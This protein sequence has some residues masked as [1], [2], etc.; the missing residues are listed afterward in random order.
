MRKAW[1]I[2]LGVLHT[3]W[4]RSIYD[5]GKAQWTVTNEAKNI[6]VP[7]KWPSQVHLDL[8]AA[9]VIDDPYHGLNDFN[10]RWIAAQNWTYASN[11]IKGLKSGSGIATWLVF[12]GLDTYTTIKLCDEIIAAT[13]NQFRQYYYDVTQ[14]VNKCNSPVLSINFGSAP[15]IID[16]I[17]ASPGQEQW[18]ASVV[19]PFEYPNR[20]FVRKEQ[21]DFGWDWGP[22]FAPAGPW[23]AGR[24]VQLSQNKELYEL[25]TD[26]D[27]YR[28]GQFN[29]FSPDQSQPWVVNASI[30]F[31]GNLPSGH[32]IDISIKE[33][34]N[35]KST[36]YS[37]RLNNLTSSHLTT[38]GTVT[39]GAN[40]PKLWWPNGL[41]SPNL[42]TVTISVF[43]SK[44]NELLSVQKR[45]GFRTIVLNTGNVTDA[46][47]AQ[48]TTP[49]SN[50]HFEIN[51]H[52]FYAK[53]SNL[54]PPDAFWPRVT[55]DR[56]NHLFESALE[57]NHNMIRVWSSGIYL[58]D[59]MY[60]MA[61]ERG[62]L[63][64]SEFE[65]SDTLYPDDPAFKENVIAEVTYNVRRLNRHPSIAS[66]I[67]GNEFENLLLPI[68]KGAD[69]D[70]YG[71][72]LGQYEDL[73]I[74][75]IFP[76]VCENSHSISYSPSSA[77]HGWTEIDL[78][79]P[80]PMVERYDNTTPGYIYG[81][82]DFYN[83]DPSVSFDYSAYPVGRF[84][85]EF[86]YHSM[87]SLASWQQAIDP[88]D[89]EFNSTVIVFRNHHSPMGGLSTTNTA[90]SLPGMGQM[91]MAVQ[92][93]YP[94]PNKADSV[95]NFSAWCHAT[96]IFQADMYKSEVQFYRRGSGMPE[97]QLGSL[98]WQLNDIWQAPTWAGIE[99]DGRWKVMPYFMKD[100]FQNVIVS[101]FY[102]YGNG[103]LEIWV[104]SDLWESVS[105]TVNMTW[106]NL[107][108][109]PIANNAG[110]PSSAHFTVGAINTTLV[111]RT[112]VNTDLTLPD[113]EDA[114]LLLSVSA[115]G[116][117]PN[118][119]KS[120]TFT[121]KNH[122]T[123]AF[124]N[125][126]KLRNPELHLSYNS[127]T[128]KF[129]V[130]SASKGGVS[131]YTWLTLPSGA[132]GH[133]DD[134][135]FILLPGEK[136]EVGFTLASD[137]TGGNWVNDVTVESIWDQ[138]TP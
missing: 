5:L 24:F 107:A 94:I 109:E 25:N 93:Y 52:E 137:S 21:S 51:G 47:I 14:I 9:G 11:P 12:D 61:D 91:T 86:G 31:I 126:A 110:M 102:N 114:L 22:A 105:G 111:H 74:S 113:P 29:N 40:A 65:F 64:W 136:K 97:R 44:H 43:D 6:T 58:P 46:Q 26:I 125:K 63:L 106:L 32:Y 54:V 83:Y 15:N 90:N 89:L 20:Q 48:G 2:S 23:R 116:H 38:T 95:A 80:V 68:A 73:F 78:S 135:A 119:A 98:Y 88:E 27:I 7:G 122:F 75:T 19:Y 70:N 69:P 30:D 59:F 134:N 101:P 8:Y 129:T 120:Q 50:W 82:T 115:T 84:A 96:Q 62:I 4:A 34:D 57:Q 42:Y 49:G 16:A 103:T 104:T 133:F 35:P 56:I 100:V 3:A 99:Y 18:P 33:A 45:S 60:D 117:T 37:G 13:D 130:Q 85:N 118:S 138:T 76:L 17:A 124:M 123:P 128:E 28:Q 1:F 131:F 72:Y 77:G 121:H 39:I 41:G 55:E 112:D 132:A 36:L 92:T 71:Y 127:H 79:L 66:W 67:G 53:G 87:P 10:L 108:G 81:D